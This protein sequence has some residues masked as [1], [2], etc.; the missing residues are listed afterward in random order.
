M[1]RPQ[2]NPQKK[3]TASPAERGYPPAKPEQ[4]ERKEKGK[5]KQ[6]KERGREKC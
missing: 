4:R 2:E 6:E 1:A 3:K 5:E